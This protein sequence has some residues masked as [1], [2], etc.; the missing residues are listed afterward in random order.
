M[1][2]LKQDDKFEDL[3]ESEPL[4]AEEMAQDVGG[5]LGGGSLWGGGPQNNFQT[6]MS[7]MAATIQ[8]DENSAGSFMQHSVSNQQIFNDILEDTHGHDLQGQADHSIV[9]HIEEQTGISQAL[10]EQSAFEQLSKAAAFSAGAPMTSAQILSD[11]KETVDGLQ[12]LGHLK[13]G[14]I[15]AQAVSQLEE[16]TPL[17][18]AQANLKLVESE[19]A[20]DE[21]TVSTLMGA[22]LGQGVGNGLGAELSG[23]ASELEHINSNLSQSQLDHDVKEIYELKTGIA[24]GLIAGSI[25][26]DIAT[27]GA[28]PYLQISNHELMGQVASSLNQANFT[29]LVNNTDSTFTTIKTAIEVQDN[30]INALADLAPGNADSLQDVEEAHPYSNPGA[31]LANGTVT[32]TNDEGKLTLGTVVDGAEFGYETAHGAKMVMTFLES[33]DT[34]G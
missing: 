17:G 8:S 27:G 5:T 30:V 19:V 3:P 21:S 10:G 7:N 11:V 14:D 1:S 33:L 24:A 29:E 31:D 22:Q 28:S 32:V 20:G 13:A 9:E 26:E 6:R 16:T 18:F 23:L 15:A 12:G 25:Q 4:S 34:E 2:K